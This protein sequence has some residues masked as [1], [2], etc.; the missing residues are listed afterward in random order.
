MF[1]IKTS[2]KA[3]PGCIF[4]HQRSSSWQRAHSSDTKSLPPNPDCYRLRRVRHAS[5]LKVKYER[6]RKPKPLLAQIN[7]CL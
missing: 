3:P 4:L 6:K 2:D 5:E 1:N 7:I